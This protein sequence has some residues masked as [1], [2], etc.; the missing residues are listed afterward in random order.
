MR[1]L[2]EVQNAGRLQPA[3]SQGNAGSLPLQG[4][5]LRYCEGKS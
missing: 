5:T 1:L 3:I 4:R 2:A